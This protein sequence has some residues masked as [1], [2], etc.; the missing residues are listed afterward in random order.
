MQAFMAFAVGP[1]RRM[2]ARLRADRVTS[3]PDRR[4]Q[5]IEMNNR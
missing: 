2:H 4:T 3:R 5:T 1:G